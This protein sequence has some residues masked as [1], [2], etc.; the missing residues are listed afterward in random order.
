VPAWGDVAMTMSLTEGGLFRILRRGTLEYWCPGCGEAHAFEINSL[1]HDGRRLGWDGDVKA[2]NVSEPIR[3]TLD[4]G[5][6]C[7]HTIR[8]GVLYFDPAS[9]HPLAGKSIH[10][11]VFHR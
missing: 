10:M 8:G 5:H 2:P 9:W 11:E 3:I 4:G 7:Q 1:N 6:I